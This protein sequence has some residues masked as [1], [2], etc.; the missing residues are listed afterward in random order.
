M[1]KSSM[2][3]LYNNFSTI[4]VVLFL[5]A[6]LY[7]WVSMFINKDIQFIAKYNQR[8][9]NRVLTSEDLHRIKHEIEHMEGREF[10]IF[11]QWLFKH[12]GKYK[13]VILT[14]SVNDEG[15]DLILTDENNDTIFVECKRYTSTATSTEE[16]M[17]GRE[18]CQKLVGAIVAEGINQGIIITTGNVHQNAWD[19]I[20]KMD[21]N[22]SVHIDIMRLDDIMR[23]IQDINS[24]EVLEVVGLGY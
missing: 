16:Y 9:K 24:P 11:S 18:I 23:T 19:Y 6:I 5:S 20:V 8:Y 4:V 15:K 3:F 2:L 12:I 14:P 13:S 21:K 7:S 17:I 1:V 10:E 22:S